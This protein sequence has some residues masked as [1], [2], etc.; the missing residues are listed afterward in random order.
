MLVESIFG[1]HWLILRFLSL[2]CIFGNFASLYSHWG[3]GFHSLQVPGHI[4]TSVQ[5]TEHHIPFGKQLSAIY[6]SD[7]EDLV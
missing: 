5:Q 3:R 2:L 1:M 6:I 4:K 7:P